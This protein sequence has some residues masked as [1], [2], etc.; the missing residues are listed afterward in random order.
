MSINE[1][2]ELELTKEEKAAIKSL[3]RLAKRWPS[4]LWIF[5]G[6]SGGLTIIKKNQDGY[7]ARISTPRGDAVDQRYQVDEIKI[8][9]DGGDY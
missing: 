3:K 6:S 1:E 4:S 9:A 8:E 7:Q 2:F 5:A